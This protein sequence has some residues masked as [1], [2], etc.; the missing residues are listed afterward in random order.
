MKD[1]KVNKSF[2]DE[3]KEDISDI[4]K[5]LTNDYDTEL[6]RDNFV[7]GVKNFVSTKR[8]EFKEWLTDNN[9]KHK[10]NI[11]NA[12]KRVGEKDT[13][14]RKIDV[15]EIHLPLFRSLIKPST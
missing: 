1:T 8:K 6:L 14:R 4:H 5:I 2:W 7:I 13:R 3:Y 11:L 15:L 9:I 10:K 12:N